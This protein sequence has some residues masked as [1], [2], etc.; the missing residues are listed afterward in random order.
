MI[1]AVDVARMDPEMRALDGVGEGEIGGDALPDPVREDCVLNEA[2]RAV[3]SCPFQEY[4]GLQL[5]DDTV[6]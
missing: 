5:G 6:C 4:G 1:V 3:C 2:L